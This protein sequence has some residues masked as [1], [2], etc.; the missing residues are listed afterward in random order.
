MVVSGIGFD[1]LNGGI[2]VRDRLRKTELGREPVINA[3]P[4][5]SGVGQNVEERPDIGA[6]ASLIKAPAVDENSGGKRS[7]TVRHVKIEQQR[8][9]ARVAEFNLLLIQRRTGQTCCIDG[10]QSEGGLPH[11]LHGDKYKEPGRR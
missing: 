6:P 4:G 10:R 11:A 8:L 1:P 9:S 2:D 3:E 5:E 7:I